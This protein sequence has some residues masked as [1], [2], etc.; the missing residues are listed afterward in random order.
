M[1]IIMESINEQD[2]TKDARGASELMRWLSVLLIAT[3][4][5][6]CDEKEKQDWEYEIGEMAVHKLTADT[7]IVTGYRWSASNVVEIRH[8]DCT[9][10]TVREEELRKIPQ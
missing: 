8:K 6:S 5:I 9:L 3:A 7:V 2:S 4:F 1:D 10:H